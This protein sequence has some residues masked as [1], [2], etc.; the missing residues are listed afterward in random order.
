MNLRI[1]FAATCV[2]YIVDYDLEYCTDEEVNFI[3]RP[4]IWQKEHIVV[5][6]ARLQIFHVIGADVALP[7]CK[8]LTK[9]N[10]EDK[11]IPWDQKESRRRPQ[12]NWEAELRRGHMRFHGIV[13]DSDTW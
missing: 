9:A 2:I 13:C 6:G 10:R 12:M 4:A 11:D 1:Q 7:A 5:D 3:R 8:I